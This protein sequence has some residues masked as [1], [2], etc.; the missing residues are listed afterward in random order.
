M[1]YDIAMLQDD[2]QNLGKVTT[3]WR[4]YIPRITEGEGTGLGGDELDIDPNTPEAA[5][6]DYF[7]DKYGIV[8]GPDIAARFFAIH[9]FVTRNLHKLERRGLL[10][11]RRHGPPMAEDLLRF[12]LTCFDDPDS[13]ERLPHSIYDPA[14]GLGMPFEAIIADF[15]RLRVL[16]QRLIPSNP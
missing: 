2:I 10:K 7:L 1:H 6:Y 4:N 12:L 3:G 5:A 8:G 11:S 16:R 13:N 14:G 9:A 15:H